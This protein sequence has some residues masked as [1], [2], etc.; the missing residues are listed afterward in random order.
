MRFTVKA[1]LASAFG[2][3]IVL[4]MITGAIAY[5]KLTSLDESQQRIVA[6]AGRSKK[7]AHVMDGIQGQQRAEAR[8]IAAV[9]DKDTKDSYDTMLARR[10]KTLKIRDEL[11]GA[12]SD[13]GKRMLDKAMGPIKQMN[14][15]E[16]QAGKFALLTQTTRRP[17]SG[18][19]RDNRR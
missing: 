19:I 6:Q 10:N 18:K 5:T 15:L 8:M 4:S 1:K 7:A 11:Y 17:N 9:S 13:V 16:D 14:E 3:V 12:A 2:A